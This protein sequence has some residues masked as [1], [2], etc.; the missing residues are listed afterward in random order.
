MGQYSVRPDRGAGVTTQPARH[1]RFDAAVS[2]F[3]LALCQ[4]ELMLT[5]TQ[6][7]RPVLDAALI[8]GLTVPLFWRRTAPLET[9]VVVMLVTIGAAVEPNGVFTLQSADIVLFLPPYAAGAYE[10][11]GRRGLVGLAVCLVGT[12]SAVAI[13]G[14]GAYWVLFSL[15]MVSGS[16]AVGRMVG[17]RRA[18]AVSLAR[19]QQL[20]RE[21]HHYLE[22][23]AIIDERERIACD[24]QIIVADC[25]KRMIDRSRHAEALLDTDP[26]SAEDKITDIE[27]TGQGA[28]DE[29]RR[30]L[31]LLRDESDEVVLTP[32]PGVGQLGSLLQEARNR[33]WDVEFRVDGTPRPLPATVNLAIYRAVEYALRG[34]PKPSDPRHPSAVVV[35]FQSDEVGVEIEGY[36]AREMHLSGPVRDRIALAGGRSEHSISDGRDVWRLLL[37]ATH[38]RPVAS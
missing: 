16:W 27:L 3:C 28:L 30:L 35:A 21:E 7:P 31:D 11:S 19:T 4:T 37:P 8:A 34:T 15:G 33:G 10:G 38:L 6:H 1:R 17:T 2:V 32:Q 14:T 20:M 24:L 5:W 26:A 22:R 29:M 9:C 25:L 18:L 23:L 36:P 12:E 13:L